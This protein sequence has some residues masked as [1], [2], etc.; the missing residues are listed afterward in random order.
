MLR[1][2][3]EYLNGK[4]NGKGIQY[5]WRGHLEFEGEYLND[6]K[7][8]GIGREYNYDSLIF[9]GEY[10]NGNVWNGNRYNADENKLI[11]IKEGHYEGK[12]YR[13]KDLLSFEGEYL[14]GKRNGKGKEYYIYPKGQVLFEGEYLNG[15][16]N[17]KGKEYNENGK[18]IFKVNILMVKKLEKLKNI[19]IILVI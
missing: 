11:E 3:G 16:R 7:W 6:E 19:I 5:S 17:G 13:G 14:N 18:L 12:E 15:K 1:F 9:Q 8:N 10:K 4:R 2:E